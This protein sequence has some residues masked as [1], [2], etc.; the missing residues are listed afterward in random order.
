MSIIKVCRWCGY[1]SFSANHLKMR[2]CPKRP[3]WAIGGT[4]CSPK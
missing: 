1:W 4:S 2:E 3:F